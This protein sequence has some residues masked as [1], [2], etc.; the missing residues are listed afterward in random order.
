MKKNL[1]NIKKAMVVLLC[2]SLFF[3]VGCKASNDENAAQKT[4][5][6]TQE[7]EVQKKA[8][9]PTDKYK[10]EEGKEYVLEWAK[11]NNAQ[12]NENP[13][14]VKHFEE[15]L[16]VKFNVWSLDPNTVYEQLALKITSG[17]VPDIF[18]VNSFDNYKDYV[19]KE[20]VM[21]LDK[22]VIK[23][24]APNV[25][26]LYE[27]EA[28]G[29]FD[30]Y[31]IDGKLY[32]FPYYRDHHVYDRTPVVWRGDWLKKVGINK[33]PET[34]AEFEEALYKFTR[35]DPDE[36]GKNDTYG[37]ANTA[38]GLFYG[39]FGQPYGIWFEKDGKLTYSAVQPEVKEALTYLAKWYED[40][41]I[42]P[43]FMDGENTGGYW[44]VT[45]SFANGK[46][47]L[48][49][50]GNYYHWGTPLFEGHGGYTN[51]AEVNKVNPE[52]AES[53][54][55]GLPP[56]GPDGKMGAWHAPVV[57]GP[58]NCIGISVE[59][60]PGKLGKI[61]E[62]LNYIHSSKENYW[63]ARLGIEG[64]HWEFN[65]HNI[66]QTIPDT[67]STSDGGN[68]LFPICEP[69][70]YSINEGLMKFG[71]KH[72]FNVGGVRNKLTVALPSA[73]QYQA[74]LNTLLNDAINSIILGEKPVSYYDEI[75]QK[76]HKSGGD[77]LTKEANEWYEANKK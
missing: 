26:K 1:L 58:G 59:K 28:P 67:D 7:N 57:A 15:K 70:K 47:G 63:T 71:E 39:A 30:I 38:M 32:G 64:F 21:E 53:L 24:Y 2:V 46:I 11:A 75:I 4:S 29:A 55:F 44:A 72:K 73:S 22:D 66:P 41:V 13:L 50:M 48:T 61:L 77:I 60:D 40:G 43:D 68:T 17:E 34:V 65:E 12:I 33:T 74:E 23:R 8:E 10:P 51:Y 62:V 35:E 16:G 18:S 25:Y 20:V 36:N 3:C 31:K 19:E 76:W 27:E 9:D 14:I 5:E 69:I 52:A 45:H 54:V 49:S 6:D 42:D 56:K 37:M